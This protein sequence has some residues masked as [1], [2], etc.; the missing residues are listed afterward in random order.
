MNIQIDLGNLAVGIGTAM[1]AVV[2]LYVSYKGFRQT[3]SQKLAEFRKDW[4]ENLRSHFSEFG[5]LV[6]H[7]RALKRIT[8][9]HT[10]NKE[11]DIE[12][13]ADE[14]YKETFVRLKYVHE[15]I[16]LMLNPS[17]DLHRQM[18]NLMQDLIDD[19]LEN[20]PETPREN[21]PDFS[22]LARQILKTEWNRVK[23]ET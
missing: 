22:D 3:K 17:E 23:T 9:M 7:A 10:E 20:E 13:K 12:N 19:T 1:I 8:D 14:D 11:K 2:T 15:Y 4:I 18:D 5:S 21:W 6:F 16:R